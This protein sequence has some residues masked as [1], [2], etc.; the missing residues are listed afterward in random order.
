DGR[1]ADLDDALVAL[2]VRVLHVDE[3]RARSA[4]VRRQ[5]RRRE[6]EALL[7]DVEGGEAAGLDVARRDAVLLHLRARRRVGCGAHLLRRGALVASLD[8]LLLEARDLLVRG[9]DGGRRGDVLVYRDLAGGVAGV[10]RRARRGD[11][12]GLGA[13]DER[14]AGGGVDA[15]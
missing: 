3:D 15:P 10:D 12:D 6:D 5:D 8:E 14:V 2:L 13:R 1:G 9:H 11:A 4:V 7:D